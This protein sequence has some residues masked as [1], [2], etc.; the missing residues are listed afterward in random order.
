MTK[1]IDAADLP[2]D[3][4]R[5]AQAQV[6]AGLSSD[7]E[8]VIRRALEDQQRRFDAK[9]EKLRGAL[10]EGEESGEAPEGTIDR[11]IARI[12]AKTAARSAP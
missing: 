5:I 12:Q 8:G 3:I 11:V 7:V 10:I 4:A 6:A 1:H 2:D 9:I